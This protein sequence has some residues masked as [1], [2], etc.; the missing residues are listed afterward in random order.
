MYLGHACMYVSERAMNYFHVIILIIFTE[1]CL[2][3]ICTCSL[4]CVGRCTR[5]FWFDAIGCRQQLRYSY[6]FEPVIQ[7]SDVISWCILTT[8]LRV[9]VDLLFSTRQAPQRRT[10][11]TELNLFTRSFC[12]KACV[13]F[14]Y[15]GC[16]NSSCSSSSSSS[17]FFFFY[18]ST[19]ST[20]LGF[21]F[22][23]TAA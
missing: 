5:H 10:S 21:S 19:A 1:L 7:D 2:I 23:F 22:F 18:N 3:A 16:R 20:F 4:G 17:S 13:E 9:L 14:Y 12:N 15:F 6:R 8:F 11:W